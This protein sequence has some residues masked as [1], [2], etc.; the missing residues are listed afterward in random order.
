MSDG[1]TTFSLRVKELKEGDEDAIGFYW[2]L[3]EG[4]ET[5]CHWEGPESS[6]EAAK[7]KAVQSIAS[8]YAAA[9][10]ELLEGN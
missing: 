8:G 6:P 9:A 4:P 2:T 7:E 3:D 10:R 1:H 5:E